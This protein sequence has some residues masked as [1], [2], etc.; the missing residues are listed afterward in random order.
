MLPSIYFN[1]FYILTKI[2]NKIKFFSLSIC[3]NTNQAI[4]VMSPKMLPRCRTESLLSMRLFLVSDS[5]NFKTRSYATPNRL[6]SV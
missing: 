4:S 3:N 2:A 6:H 1:T 5:F